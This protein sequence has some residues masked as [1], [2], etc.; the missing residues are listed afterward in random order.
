[1][2]SFAQ[3]GLAM[4][5][6]A[7]FVVVWVALIFVSILVMPWPKEAKEIRDSYRGTVVLIGFFA[8]R[9]LKSKMTS[10]HLLIFNKFRKRYVFYWL[11]ILAVVLVL[12]I[13]SILELKEENAE[14]IDRMQKEF[15]DK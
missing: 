6:L 3:S 15:I 10:D 13:V 8:P 1:M 11:V 5:Y 9:Y 7:I 2:Y 14:F 4:T 12:S